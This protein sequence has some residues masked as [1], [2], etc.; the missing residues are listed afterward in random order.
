[1]G[2]MEKYSQVAHMDVAEVQF[3]FVIGMCASLAVNA[4]RYR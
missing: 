1:M 4:W 2:G 3:V